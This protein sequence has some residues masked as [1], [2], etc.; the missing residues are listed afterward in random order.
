MKSFT[1]LF[2][3]SMTIFFTLFDHSL[4]MIFLSDAY[5][6]IL[7]IRTFTTNDVCA[8]IS[9]ANLALFHWPASSMPRDCVCTAA[10]SNQSLCTCQIRC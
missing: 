5:E 9:C 3:F 10:G 1:M 6:I 4:G 2:I 8:N 7:S